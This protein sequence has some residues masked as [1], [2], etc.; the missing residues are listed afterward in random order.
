MF[1]APLPKKTDPDLFSLIP[2]VQTDG[3]LRILGVN[4]AAARAGIRP[5]ETVRTRNETE[6]QRFRE[7]YASCVRA[8][9]TAAYGTDCETGTIRLPLTAFHAFRTALV[10]FEYSLAGSFA[11]VVLFRSQ[12]EFLLS[13]IHASQQTEKAASFFSAHFLRLRK[14]C[15]TLLRT[16]EI[17]RAELAET[18]GSLLSAMSFSAR[19]LAPIAA[20]NQKDK[21]LFSLSSLVNTYVADVLPSLDTVDCHVEYVSDG[22]DVLLPVDTSALFLL[23][24]ILFSLMNSLSADGCIRL[25]HSRYGQD[26]E[27]R[28]S[29]AYE[30]D[31][32]PLSHITSLASLSPLL[33]ETEMQL[34]AADY[35]ASVTDSYPD[36]SADPAKKQLTLSLYIPYEKQAEDFKS[37]KGVK[38][39]LQEACRCMRGFFRI[40]PGFIGE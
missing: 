19:I 1:S 12:K 39:D 3:D 15:E 20:E 6:A 24:S 8:S 32:P 10:R 5:G 14:E 23:L 13:P 21:R 4:D 31:L 36:V 34:F 40:L 28:L 37:P 18:L 7:W 25:S 35:L 16:P 17:D 11:T 38:E 9:Q 29:T 30:R 27:F 22:E 33:P 26:G 2:S